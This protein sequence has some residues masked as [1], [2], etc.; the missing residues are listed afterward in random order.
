MMPSLFDDDNTDKITLAL[1]Y[2]GVS[3]TNGHRAANLADSTPASVP[4][5]LRVEPKP[6]SGIR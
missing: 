3:F 4:L 5:P 2:S 1:S 6:K